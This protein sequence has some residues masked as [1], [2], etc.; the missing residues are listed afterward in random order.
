[1]L[2]LT[3]QNVSVFGQVT[4]E[5]RMTMTR[6][7]RLALH[8]RFNAARAKLGPADNYGRQSP[9]GRAQRELVARLCRALNYLGRRE[10]YA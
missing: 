9:E 1:M 6:K 8:R 4:K 7:T 5:E 10:L 3:F 2:A